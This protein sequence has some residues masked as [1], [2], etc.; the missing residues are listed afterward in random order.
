MP[1]E[2]MDRRAYRTAKFGWEQSL[3]MD[4]RLTR[5]GLSDGV[6]FKFPRIKRTANTFNAHRLTRL[7]SAVGAQERVAFELLK[8]YFTEALDI[9]RREVL[10][11]A[12]G[13]CG[14]D[15]DRVAAM[16]DGDALREELRAAEKRILE[17][18]IQSVPS[19]VVNG[20]PITSGA[21]KPE[22]LAMELRKA[23]R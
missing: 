22:L 19:Y 5:L 13:R 1:S 3:L 18:G 14:L 20:V 23:F 6:E 12:A 10:N 15:R 7:A 2:G 11:E 16:L 21:L 9:G 17:I 8:M 4:D